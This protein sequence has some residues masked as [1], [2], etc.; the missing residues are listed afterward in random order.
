M[1]IAT[2]AVVLAV[3]AEYPDGS[4]NSPQPVD[5]AKVAEEQAFAA[6]AAKQPCAASADFFA[7]FLE[8]SDAR[9]LRNAALAADDAGDRA[10]ARDLWSELARVKS[11]FLDEALAAIKK[12]AS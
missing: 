11:P 10:R 6:L 9:L 4:P 7:A 8:K 3:V 5:E 12:D 2:F 1:M